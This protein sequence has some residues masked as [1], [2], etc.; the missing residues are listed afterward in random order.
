MKR[1]VFWLLSV[2]AAGVVIAPPAAQACGGF[3]CGQT[4]VDQS[5]EQIL[6]SID[7]GHVTAHIQIS[8]TGAAS[9]F[10]W[11]VPVAS[12][13]KISVGSKAVFQQLL[14]RTQP[15]FNV[16]WSGNCGIYAGGADNGLGVPSG[17][18]GGSSGSS[19]P[20]VVVLQSGEVGPYD[21]VVLQ[22]TDGHALVDWLNTNHFQ[23][24]A[25]AQPLIDHYV[26]LGM[27]F[28]GL[29]LKKDAMTGDIQPIVLDMDNDEACVPLIL[30][31]IAATPNMPVYVFVLGRNRAVPK[32]WFEVEVNEK[33]IDW[34]SFGSNY[35]QLATLAI[36]EAAGHGFI[37]EY[38]G[39]SNIMQGALYVPGQ[40]NTDA[41]A[42]ITSPAAFLQ[43]IAQ[44]G[45]PRDT[46]MLALLRKYI[47][48]PAS[49]VAMG[50]N[51]QQF[52][53]QLAV[54]PSA[55][56]DAL[57]NQPFDPA[58]FAADLKDRVVKPLQ[59]AQT[60]FDTE[61]YLTRLYSTVSPEEMNRD[62]RFQFNADL[63]QVS[64]IHRALGSGS[65]NA[66]DGT[67]TDVSLVFEDGQKLDIPG[68]VKGY[69]SPWTY[70]SDQPAAQRIALQGASGS[71]AVYTKSQALAADKQLDQQTPDKV[72][73]AG[74]AAAASGC[75]VGPGQV[76]I[77]GVSALVMLGLALRRRRPS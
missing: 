53:N 4:P 17:G 32:N 7:G 22:S 31:Q 41:L 52:Y 3:F 54:D 58:A 77:A 73:A 8:Y 55:Y 19:A 24:P 74:K 9:D 48:E 39:P 60:L 62:P 61:P 49:L 64:N 10:A 40:W 6:F 30:T 59:D 63:K 68:T 65:C 37:T 72:V 66:N 67:I 70:A 20:P 14:P 42:A 27:L 51:E 56:Q 33:R 45:L 28:V 25:S 38:A 75:S 44:M 35:A 36:D 2:C 34:F 29:R 18:T 15:Q 50:V 11:V 21:T 46:T 12:V 1:V 71:P 5:G 57:A 69:G 76:G 16:V 26:G 47:P 13:P 23:Q 43:A